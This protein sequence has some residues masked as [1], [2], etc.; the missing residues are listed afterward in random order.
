MPCIHKEVWQKFQKSV[1]RFQFY[2]LPSAISM[3]M[4]PCWVLTHQRAQLFALSVITSA[5]QHKRTCN[6]L[7]PREHLSLS[8]SSSLPLSP[9]ITSIWGQRS[10]CFD[11]EKVCS[12]KK[13]LHFRENAVATDIFFSIFKSLRRSRHCSATSGGKGMDAA[14]GRCTR[15]KYKLGGKGACNNESLWMCLRVRCK[16]FH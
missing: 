4:C 8:S 14:S 11:N 9:W 13:R 10:Q 15:V 16:F 12:A 3:R 2:S 1:T 5:A 7:L 6:W